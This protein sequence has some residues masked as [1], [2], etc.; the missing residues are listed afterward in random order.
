M[1]RAE[2]PCMTVPAP[3]PANE[4][5]RL[6]LLRDLLVLDSAPEPLFD[7]LARMA[8]ETC[9]TPIAL[10]SLVDAERQW[11]K[12]NVGLDGVSETPRDLA[13]CAH[14]ILQ[15]GLME[16][17]DA[18]QDP[19]FARNPLVTSAPDIRFYVGA[20]LSLPGG[21]RMGTLCVIDHRPRQLTSEQART[22]LQLAELAT[23]ALL[24]RRDLIERS[25]RARSAH[26]AA[27][28]AS[29]AHHRSLVEGQ[30]ELVALSQQ[31]S[32]LAYVNPAYARHLG[33]TPQDL[34][35]RDLYDY[36][37][38][39]DRD[40]ARALADQVLTTGEPRS[41]E[42]RM[43]EPDGQER[44]IA[45]THTRRIDTQGCPMLHSV[46]RDVT[47]RKQAEMRLAASERFLRLITD[48][49]PVRISYMD[50]ERRYRF[51]NRA[52]AERFHLPRDQVLGYSRSELLQ[53]E[54]EPNMRARSDAALAGQAQRF[55]FEEEVDG[56]LRR[57]DSQLI[58]DIAA[59]GTVR[60]I[61]ITGIDI[62]E[63]AE[64]D[65]ALLR[66]TA[67]LQSV[68]EA[69]PALVAVIGSDGRYRFVNSAFER[70]HGLARAD[71]IG[72]SLHDVLDDTEFDPVRPGLARALAGDTFSHEMHFPQRSAQ[73]LSISYIPLRL[74]N[75]TLDGFVA[76]AQDITH[77][78][79]EALRLLDLSQ[80]DTLTG[81]LNRAGF[82]AYLHQQLREQPADALTLLCID[83]DHFK[84]V[85]DQHGHP[86][87]DAVLRQFAER[88]RA[89]V[90]PLDA[91]ARLG[92]DEFAVVLAGV[93]E[94][95]RVQAVAEQILAAAHTPFFVGPLTLH[96]GASVGA[97]QGMQAHPSWQD[98]LAR[99]D[100][101]LYQAK[102]D[103]R[104]RHAG[105]G[106]SGS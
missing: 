19:R 17:R 9:G 103:G 26:E 87:G 72:R 39:Q 84:P 56:Q 70:W 106:Q 81:L 35:D 15:G 105:I 34:L 16:V 86:T 104:G 59:D 102:R 18:Q 60:G 94:P 21:E 100:V 82:E 20:P 41:G 79:H 96:I 95:T 71:V 54:T 67:T 75:G 55:E 28:F 76:I 31:D 13:F 101:M 22:L 64:T 24:M 10:L 93:R 30:S 65:R 7:S 80:R 74:D 91:V 27:L 2:S 43:V 1:D 89:L 61:F 33:H 57:I 99:A 48:S 66:Q 51:A 4:A 47:E 44:W 50:H 45:W 29:E 38:P 46:G 3:L 37:A 5:T 68:A 85:N 32:R 90:R 92:G 49:L 63:R 77:H 14:A 40:A 69:I 78:R 36:I 97:A 58:P 23:Q 8:S 6:A 11:F 12:A 73:H 25:L 98:L 53:R 52:Q 83:L 88:L 62:T 42:N